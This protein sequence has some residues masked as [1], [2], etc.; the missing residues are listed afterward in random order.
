MR[1]QS[2][3]STHD[4]ALR[5]LSS[6]LK[7]APAQRQL[8]PRVVESSPAWNWPASLWSGQLRNDSPQPTRHTKKLLASSMRRALLGPTHKDVSPP[9]SSSAKLTADGR[10]RGRHRRPPIGQVTP[11]IFLSLLM[12]LFLEVRP[13]HLKRSS[14]K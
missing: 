7:A 12:A 4:L 9:L 2:N 14:T 5:L 6:L 1:E 10:V 8:S 13:P 3:N 11:W